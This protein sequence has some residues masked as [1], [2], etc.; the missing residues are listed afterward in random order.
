MYFLHTSDYFL[1]VLA[2][3]IAYLSVNVSFH[4]S[5]HF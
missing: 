3:G 4:V 5:V 1:D 2:K